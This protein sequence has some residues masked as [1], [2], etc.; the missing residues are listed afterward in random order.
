M[1]LRWL[2]LGYHSNCDVLDRKTT[3]CLTRGMPDAEPAPFGS[4]IPTA[5]TPTEFAT[6][7]V[8]GNPGAKLVLFKTSSTVFSVFLDPGS[9]QRLSQMLMA[10]PTRNGKGELHLP[11]EPRLIKPPG[12]N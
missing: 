12:V 5:P 4:Q 2:R 1:W 10:D 11:P 9:C 7:D 3:T 6:R 8:E